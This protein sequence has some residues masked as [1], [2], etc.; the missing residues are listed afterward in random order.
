MQCQPT[1]HKTSKGY[2]ILAM[3]VPE[4]QQTHRD[5][6]SFQ[7]KKNERTKKEHSKS[8]DSLDPDPIQMRKEDRGRTPPSI[9]PGIVCMVP[10]FP[11]ICMPSLNSHFVPPSPPLSFWSDRFDGPA[12]W[13]SIADSLSMQKEKKL[14]GQQTGA[15]ADTRG[16][17]QESAKKEKSNKERQRRVKPSQRG[18]RRC[19]W[20]KKQKEIELKTHMNIERALMRPIAHEARRNVSEDSIGGSFLFPSFPSSVHSS[21][22]PSFP[23]VSLGSGLSPAIEKRE[24]DETV[25]MFVNKPASSFS[26]LSETRLS[27]CVHVSV[28][29]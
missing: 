7:A 4:G 14:E 25:S 11:S 2:D 1:T 22:P 21:F 9:H 20:T 5:P 16:R 10:V 3:S 28:V 29:H 24:I 15:S 6:P 17:S 19:E 18:Q 23:A 26:F 13:I 27:D 12:C 8:L